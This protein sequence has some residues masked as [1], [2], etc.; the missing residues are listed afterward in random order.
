VPERT[1]APAARLYLDLLKRVL[2]GLATS[3]LADDALALRIEG[4][5]WP[6]H[7]ETMIGLRR[8][9]DLDECIAAVLAD[10]VPG[11]LMEC[12]VWRGG[13][14]IFMRAALEARG[15]PDRVVWL[16]DSFEGVCRPDTAVFP[17]DAGIDLYK[18]EGLAV[19]RT[20]VEAN[21]ERYGLLD[22]RVHFIEGWFR[23]TLPSAP[24]ESLALLRLDGDLYE[25]TFVALEALYPKVSPG[26]FVIVDDYG[27]LEACRL[28]VD[29]FRADYGID[30][31]I[32]P[33][34]WTGVHWRKRL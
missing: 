10:G 25:S 34:D 31:P 29:D 27:G 28:A 17:A 4:M 33:V 5:D 14:A 12:G 16:A 24:V 1:P 32:V 7:G 30:E 9:D 15:D 2:T 19:P 23:D 20:E 13:A 3:E 21:F 8:L 22:E 26:G 18:I 6:H 11:D